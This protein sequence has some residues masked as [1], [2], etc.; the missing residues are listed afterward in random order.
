MAM[1][2]DNVVVRTIINMGIGSVQV[3]EF[4]EWRDKCDCTFLNKLEYIIDF[5]CTY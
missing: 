2:S 1:K 3:R 5:L 4:C